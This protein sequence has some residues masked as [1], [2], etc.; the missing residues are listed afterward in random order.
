VTEQTM[1]VV[2]PEDI[3][4][5]VLRDGYAYWLEKK[6]D[7]LMPSRGDLDPLLERPQLCSHIILFDVMSD[8]LDFRYR[9]IGQSV[10]RRMGENWV[11]RRMSEIDFQRAPNPIWQHHAWVVEHRAPRFIR[12]EYIHPKED[13]RFVESAILPLGPDPDRVDMIFS[14]VDFVNPGS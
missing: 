11:G 9:L 10:R 6:G 1:G 13:F 5:R 14:F 4:S 12:P 2:A 8:P 3:R 7:R